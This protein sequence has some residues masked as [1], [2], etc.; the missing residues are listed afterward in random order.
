MSTSLAAKPDYNGHKLIHQIALG[1]FEGSSEIIQVGA[2]VTFR[3]PFE[4][5]KAGFPVAFG[6][7]TGSAVQISYRAAPRSDSSILQSRQIAG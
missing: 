2:A 4:V 3:D 1:L 7:D 5:L 6:T